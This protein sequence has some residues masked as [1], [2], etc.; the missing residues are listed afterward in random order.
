MHCYLSGSVH[1]VSKGSMLLCGGVLLHPKT[2]AI[3]NTAKLPRNPVVEGSAEGE[4]TRA[5]SGHL[6]ISGV[7]GLYLA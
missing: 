3:G 7:V 5:S 4:T 6:S 1:I 2:S